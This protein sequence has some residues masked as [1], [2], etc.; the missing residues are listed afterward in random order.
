MHCNLLEPTPQETIN[1]ISHSPASYNDAGVHTLAGII[2]QATAPVGIQVTGTHTTESYDD[3]ATSPYSYVDTGTHSI[4]GI[5]ENSSTPIG[6]KFAGA[7]TG[8]T[9]FDSSTS[10]AG[11]SFAGTYAHAAVFTAVGTML[12]ALVAKA[13]QNICLNGEGSGCLVYSPT[14]NALQFPGPI[15]FTALPTVGGGGGVFVCVDSAGM[16]YKKA[17]CP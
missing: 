17:S 15:A 6:L 14:Q 11:V 2:E 3:N 5:L 10:G 1:D 8:E 16:I 4:A 7:F 12:N 13:G 9:I